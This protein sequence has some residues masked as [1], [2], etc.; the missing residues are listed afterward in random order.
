MSHPNVH[1]LHAGGTGIGPHEPVVDA[2]HVVEMHARK[3]ADWFPNHEVIHADGAPG[4][5][6][7]GREGGREGSVKSQCSVTAD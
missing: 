5:G 4:E 3:K 7:G 2:P 1:T 6:E